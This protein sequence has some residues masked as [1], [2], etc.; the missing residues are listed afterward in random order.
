MKRVNQREHLPYQI[1]ASIGYVLTDPRS[2][3]E[4]DDYVEEADALMYE[5]K[6]R[7]RKHREVNSVR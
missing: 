3:R 7:N 2:K 5:V 4:L 6:K 1:E